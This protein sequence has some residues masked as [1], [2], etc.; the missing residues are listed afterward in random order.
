MTT[1]SG[2]HTAHEVLPAE[3]STGAGPQAQFWKR[4]SPRH[5]FSF[6]SAISIAVHGAVLLLLLFA[7]YL[8]VRLK[9]AEDTKPLLLETLAV[10][11]DPERIA[12]A[13]QGGPDQEP[14]QF[15]ERAPAPQRDNAEQSRPRKPDSASLLTP[16]AVEIQ[17]R[18]RDPSRALESGG[19]SVQTDLADVR[20]R[21]QEEFDRVLAREKGDRSAADAGSLGRTGGPGAGPRGPSG[22]RAGTIEQIRRTRWRLI[23]NTED[24]RD[25]LRQLHALG[26][27]LVIP[28]PDGEFRIIRDLAHPE[29]GK[30]EHLKQLPDFYWLDTEPRSK[31]SLSMA[32][33]LQT[34]PEYFVVFLPKSLEN[35]LL[36]KELQHSGVGEDRIKETHFQL[37]WRHD[38][39]DLMVVYQALR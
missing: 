23:L 10:Q 2:Q 30:A 39:Y 27:I 14:A 35:E 25:Y 37:R 3:T 36:K 33:G 12:S 11:G 1:D 17:I 21:A 38:K 16:K 28:Q 5:E 19:T 34:E 32:L 13:G 9:L 31:R 24:G 20:R 8:A 22:G 26:A 15:Q 7:S 6:S 4:Y 29:S 18:P